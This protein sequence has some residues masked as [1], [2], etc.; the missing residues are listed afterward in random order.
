ALPAALSNRRPLAW[1]VGAAL[2]GL[3]TLD[4]SGVTRGEVERIWLPYAAWVI[5]AA[6][7][8]KPPARPWLSAQTTLT[9]TL[10]ALILSP[11]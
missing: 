3:L 5:A 8:H 11:W 1:L 6:A 2:I 7:H 4:I 10:Q 9:L